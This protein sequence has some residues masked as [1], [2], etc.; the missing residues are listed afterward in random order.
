[1]L[2]DTFANTQFYMCLENGF[3][4]KTFADL[5]IYLLPN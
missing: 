3:G 1:M 2:V 4:K 5:Q